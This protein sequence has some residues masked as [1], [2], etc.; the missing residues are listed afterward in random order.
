[1]SRLTAEK[2]NE[3]ARRL[4]AEVLP[5]AEGE[6]KFALAANR[7]T[8]GEAQILYDTLAKERV[9][10]LDTEA[11][12]GWSNFDLRVVPTT[13]LL[14]FCRAKGI[15]RDDGQECPTTSKTSIIAAIKAKFPERGD[16][17]P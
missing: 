2:F 15:T 12:N 9:G 11:T 5:D 14:D 4:K 16:R 13:G 17:I 3:Q 7:P 6:A 10:I 1:M 8:Q